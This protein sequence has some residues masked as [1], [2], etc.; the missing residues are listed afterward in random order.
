MRI[1]IF[2]YT[3]NDSG[4]WVVARLDSPLPYS[5]QTA[6]GEIKLD[7]GRRISSAQRKMIYAMLKDISEFT[8]HDPLFLINYYKCDFVIQ[9][10]C[11]WFSLSTTDMTTARNFI[12]HILESAFELGAPLTHQTADL[13][14]ST[15]NYLWLCLK[16]RKCAICGAKAEAH[17]VD[18][19]GQGR[20]RNSIDHS[21]HRLMALCRVHHS[22]SH[23][24]GQE[25]FAEK[26][27]VY[28][29]KLSKEAVRELGL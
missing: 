14:K 26:Y 1:E 11:D 16:F 28:G 8:G 23:Q 29:I 13:A 25:T 18:A 20:D 15:G 7:D 10:D 24:S 2:D 22:E 21:R 19:V 6:T 3:E 5:L 27:H 12:E 4:V 17:H 9:N